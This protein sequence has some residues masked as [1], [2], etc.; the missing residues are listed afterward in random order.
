LKLYRWRKT[1][2]PDSSRVGRWS[3][4]DDKR[5]M[6]KLFGSGSW[7]KLLSSFLVTHGVNAMK[8][9]GSGDLKKTPKYWRQSMSLGL[10]GP[11]LLAWRFLIVLTICAWGK[12]VFK[13]LNLLWYVASMLSF[14]MKKNFLANIMLLET[15]EDGES[16]VKINCLQL[17]RLN[18]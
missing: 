8:I 14:I 5:L 13:L 18:K 3:L 4:D 9:F 6:V 17:R 16:C 1:L 12:A 10:V 15:S 2:N 7:I 11:R